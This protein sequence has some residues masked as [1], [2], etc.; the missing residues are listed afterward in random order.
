MNLTISLRL[1]L[2]RLISDPRK[3]RHPHFITVTQTLDP[4]AGHVPGPSLGQCR[5]QLLGIA[6]SKYHSD[7]LFRPH[8]LFQPGNSHN[9][10]LNR[11]AE[12]R[13]IASLIQAQ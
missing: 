3:P 6:V 12:T 8:W 10:G 1:N 4:N 7:A 9:F 13:L 5:Y 2:I 11:L